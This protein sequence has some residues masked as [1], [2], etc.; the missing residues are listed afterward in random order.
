MLTQSGA[1][2]GG[3]SPQECRVCEWTEPDL[4]AGGARHSGEVEHHLPTRWLYNG[5]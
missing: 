5:E 4:T 1:A 2:N 3:A